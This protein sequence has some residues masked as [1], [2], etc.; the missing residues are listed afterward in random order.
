MLTLDKI[1]K[2]FSKGE[3]PKGSEFA[4]TWKSF[5]HK[6]EKLPIE[7]IMGLAEAIAK[8]TTN[9]KGYHTDEAALKLAY[10]KADNRKDFFAW[11][12]SKPTLVWKVYAN[13]SDWVNTGDEPTEQEI[14][15]AAYAK[16]ETEEGVVL[17]SKSGGILSK[18]ISHHKN[19]VEEILD[20]ID[21]QFKI[22]EIHESKNLFTAGVV[23]STGRRH[24]DETGLGQQGYPDYSITSSF[25]FA[26]Q[27]GDVL[28][29]NTNQTIVFYTDNDKVVH[30]FIPSVS[31]VPAM[32]AREIVID[33]DGI[34]RI[35]FTFLTAWGRDNLYVK[36]RTFEKQTAGVPVKNVVLES[37]TTLSDFIA[38]SPNYIKGLPFKEKKQ[39][40]FTE[41][42]G[43]VGLAGG[44]GASTTGIIAKC[45]ELLEANSVY[46]VE[47]DEIITGFIC[48]TVGGFPLVIAGRKKFYFKTDSR[49]N[50]EFAMWVK[51]DQQVSYVPVL[52]DVRGRYRA[53][54]LEQ[55]LEVKGMPALPAVANDLSAF[56]SAKL[57]EP[58]FV[59]WNVIGNYFKM[60][61]TTDYSTE[62]V[63]VEYLDSNGNYFK[64]FAVMGGQGRT[65]MTF[66]NHNSKY[67]LMNRDGSKFV[68]TIGDLLPRSTWH[69]KVNFSDF[70]QLNNPATA[71]FFTDWY[72]DESDPKFR[73]PWLD[74]FPVDLSKVQLSRTF[75][76]RPRGIIAAIPTSICTLWNHR[77]CGTM[78]L[79]AFAENFFLDAN[80]PL[81]RGFRGDLD[82]RNKDRWEEMCSDTEGLEMTD[83]TWTPFA[84]WYAWIRANASSTKVQEFRAGDGVKF[85]SQNLIDTWLI[86]EW[87]FLSDNLQANQVWISYDSEKF[88]YM[89]YDLDS[90]FGLHAT[91]S[92]N[93]K[94][95]DEFK[96]NNQNVAIWE[97]VKRAYSIELK[98]RYAELRHNGRFSIEKVREIYGS[99]QSRF[100]YE[101]FEKD[102]YTFRN[103]KSIQEGSFA[104]LDRVYWFAEERLKFLDA[105]YGYS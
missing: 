71:T 77:S 60:T 89:W 101:W 30:S 2:I 11:V 27:K 12:G 83:E 61:E 16:I 13:G 35:A 17:R 62:A 78:N 45:T 104:S 86:A 50:Q 87:F 31:A 54:K 67:K 34:K 93:F 25:P 66:E 42:G 64:K 8:A 94:P 29:I 90:A 22:D 81:H 55:P 97:Q 102:F 21:Y 23:S 74:A 40:K 76:K 7:Q 75:D 5:W 41:V 48:A 37:G 88:T 44:I 1:I 63:E 24:S 4:E 51:G 70:A 6:T 47:I 100:D 95:T 58:S 32:D 43:Y 10:P 99:F 33:I 69:F 59:I 49:E 14:D 3:T 18:N 79:N 38:N 68:L 96:P 57:P 39:L 20:G 46:Y 105:K 19:D 53:Y 15:L 36:H 9:F 98:E 52:F 92:V 82:D 72:R 80:N 85:D 65:S 103:R 91:G 26:P 84:N 73:Y 28:L 56:P